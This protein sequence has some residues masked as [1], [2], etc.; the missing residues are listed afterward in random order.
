MATRKR[1][2]SVSARVVPMKQITVKRRN[3]KPNFRKLRDNT[4]S[5]LT[6]SLRAEL[7]YFEWGVSVNPAIASTGVYVFAAN[8]LFDVNTTGAGHQP[9]GYDQIMALYNEYIVL[10]STI[11]VTYANSDSGQDVICGITLADFNNTS[12]DARVYIENGN[13]VWTEIGTFKS[14]N[15]IATLRHSADIAKYSTQAVIDD[16]NFSANALSNPVDTH[17]YHVW[18]GPAD[19]SADVGSIVLNVEIRF[20]CLFRD[21]SQTAL[22]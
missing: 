14:G 9:A 8:G 4:I 2:R 17:Y 10:G 16:D 11:K 21:P 6:Q 5:K 18:A 22:S 3:T 1:A 13:T 12:N 19:A 15:D 20:D 7:I